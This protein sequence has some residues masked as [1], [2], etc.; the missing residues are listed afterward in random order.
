MAVARS[1]ARDGVWGVTPYAFTSSTSSLAWPLLLALADLVVGVREATPLVLNLLFA[2]AALLLADRLLRGASLGL[3]A[4]A[5]VA[6]VFFTPL[7]TLVLSGMEHTLH[8]AA[9]FWLLDRVRAAEEDGAES[10]RTLG[11]LGMAAALAAAARYE[12]LFLIAPAAAVLWLDR[13]RRAAITAVAAAVLPLAVYAAVS[14]AHGWPPLPNSLLLK[15]ATFAGSGAS[16]LFD[17]FG[18]HALRML[19]EAPHLL[20][21][22]AAVI[23]LSARRTTPAAVRRWDVIFVTGT[24]LHLQLA[25]LGWLFRYEAYLV[26]MGVVLVARHLADAP[27]GLGA[28]GTAT[29]AALTV[30]VLVAA[31]PLLARAVQAA[32]QT[33]RAA[34]NIYE[35]Q[36][37]MGLFLRGLPAGST[38]MANDIGAVAYLADVRLVD[39][40]GLATRETARARREG[41]VDRA[42]LAHL[43]AAAPP[44][45][46]V[47]YRSWFA[48]AIPPDW[49]QVGTWRVPEEV[50]VADR[51]VTFYATR[52]AEA[53]LL[54]RAL[55][56][57]QA[58][59]PPTVTVRLADAAS[60]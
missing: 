13:R 38:V 12:S 9:V 39:L 43:A 16:A 25:A 4:A 23:L 49:I 27:A 14:V 59:L 8:I 58:R 26:A 45:A 40:Y 57:F 54:A 36:Y 21:L 31:F 29:R 51:T 6:L 37:Q 20:V 17:R 52:P 44:A 32:S 7:P 42:L 41:R 53:A 11:S 18:G 5:L 50:V 24:L 47:V 15:R 33:P 19:G 48:D 60:P 1:L 2:G 28:F 55:D 46:V 30:A 22:L 10:L 35:Q 56:A 3:R 34:K